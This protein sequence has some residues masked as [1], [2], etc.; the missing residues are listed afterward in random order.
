VTD[1]TMPHVTAP[2]VPVM[3]G[4]RD[5]SVHNH[6]GRA[7][8]YHV[9]KYRGDVPHPACNTWSQVVVETTVRPAER[10]EPAL[11]CQGHGCRSRWPQ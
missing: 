3:A 11:R 8:V 2:A 4:M 6:P 9:V 7:A 1:P 10:V 5:A